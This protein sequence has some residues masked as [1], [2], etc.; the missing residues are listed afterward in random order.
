MK[1]PSKLTRQWLKR[2][3]DKMASKADVQMPFWFIH[4]AGDE[5]GTFC[6]DCGEKRRAQL[7]KNHKDDKDVLSNLVFLDGGYSMECDSCS[8]C[9][10]CGQLLQYSLTDYGCESE[11]DHFRENGIDVSSSSVAYHI[12]RLLYSNKLEGIG[13]VELTGRLTV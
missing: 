10:T 2:W 3:A 8:H 4:N 11:W 9:A 5:D 6:F 12:Q 7:I 1:K 13:K